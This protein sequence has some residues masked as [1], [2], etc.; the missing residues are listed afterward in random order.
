LAAHAP[1][2]EPDERVLVRA[3]ASFRGALAASLRSTFALSAARRRL[4]SYY[5]WREPADVA[6]FATTGPEMVLGLT[7]RRLVVWS[8]SFWSGRPRTIT[9]RIPLNKIH[10]VAAVRHGMVTGLAVV[11]T[12]GAIVEVEAIRGRRLRHLANEMRQVAGGG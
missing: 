11:F 4:E 1:G 3:P 7:D 9:A 5:A 8:T 2:L 6:G 12:S 10:D